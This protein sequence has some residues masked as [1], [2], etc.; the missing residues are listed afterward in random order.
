MTSNSNAVR[1]AR[2]A[3]GVTMLESCVVC[4]IVAILVSLALASFRSAIQRKRLE[5]V[6]QQFKTDFAFAHSEALIRGRTVQLTFM[7]TGSG[8][9]YIIHSTGECQCSVDALPQCYG[10][11][12]PIKTVSLP[13][14]DGIT[15]RTLPVRIVFDA[16]RRTVTPAATIEFQ[17]GT[18]AR[19]KAVVNIL[20]RMRICAPDEA[21]AGYRR[22]T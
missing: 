10:D 20:G 14:S 5:G 9:C 3:R 1:M 8:S 22:C 16:Q 11:A 7:A 13:A 12:Q 6:A 4:A 19:L 15:A 2:P 17:S 18:A 21:F